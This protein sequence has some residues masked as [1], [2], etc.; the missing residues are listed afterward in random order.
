ML[1]EYKYGFKYKLY[2]TLKIPKVLMIKAEWAL[3][4]LYNIN[5]KLIIC[6]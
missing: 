5:L 6:M 2:K 3:S 1:P 4:A